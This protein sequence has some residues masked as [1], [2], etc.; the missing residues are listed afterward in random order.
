MLH[1]APPA[2]LTTADGLRL[3]LRHW[4]CETARG[5]VLLVHGLGEHAGRYGHVAAALAQAGFETVAH[6]QRGH[7]RSEGARGDIA[8]PHA[9][10]DDLARVIDA[11][12]ARRDGP[13]LL[14]GHSLGGAVAARFV[15][16]A[17][18]G[19][20]PA[21]AR[22]VE[23]LVLSSPA[24]AAELRPTQRLLLAFGSRFAP[25][26]AA[27]NG[28]DPAWVSRDPAVVAAYRADALVHDRITPMLARFTLDAGERVRADAARWR[29]PTL[30]MWAGADRCVRPAGSAAFAAA[31]PLG[32]VAARR[33]DGLAHELFNEP[34]RARVFETLADWLA[35]QR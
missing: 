30:L 19:P 8:R 22:K 2:S 32:V 7:G 12:R 5:T 23:A 13:L 1:S 31:A 20:G 27:N 28:L 17:L 6:D 10:L 29:V 26:L 21:W 25:H 33:F 11:L 4:P 3:H 9:L 24:L 14:L 35:R 16:G 15:A 34:E 18:E